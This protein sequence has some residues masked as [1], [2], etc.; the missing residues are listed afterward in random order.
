MVNKE[1]LLKQRIIIIQK[2]YRHWAKIL[3]SAL[4]E[5]SPKDRGQ[6]R[7]AI[8]YRVTV[9]SSRGVSKTVNLMVGV[10]DTNSY[11]FRYLQY[12][13]TG[14]RIHF[15][16]VKS[17]GRYTGIL[18]WAKRHGIIYHGL[19]NTG[20]GEYTWRWHGTGKVFKGMTTGMTPNNYFA[21]IHNRYRKKI[22]AS[23]QKALKGR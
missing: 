8:K 1:K 2:V 10:L 17:K 19:S 11:V 14:T 21:R 15:V 12:I 5:A 13:L 6:L 22:R 20:K 9:K 7:K 18:G 4:K 16:P 3:R 23:V